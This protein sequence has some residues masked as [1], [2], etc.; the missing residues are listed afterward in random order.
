MPEHSEPRANRSKWIRLFLFLAVATTYLVWRATRPPE[1]EPFVF[2]EPGLLRSIP[3]PG[4]GRA[5]ELVRSPVPRHLGIY[6][7]GIGFLAQGTPARVGPD[8]R[9]ELESALAQWAPVGAGVEWVGQEDLGKTP[10]GILQVDGFDLAWV[11]SASADEGS[12]EVSFYAGD[13]LNGPPADHASPLARFTMDG[14][15]MG[16]PDG[17][18]RAWMMTVDLSGGMEFLLEAPQGRFSWGFAASEEAT[19]PYLLDRGED[20]D[21]RVVAMDPRT[22]TQ[23][24][25]LGLQVPG[26]GMALALHT[27]TPGTRRIYP[28]EGLPSPTLR[29]VS[30]PVGPSARAWWRILGARPQAHYFLWV[31]DGAGDGQMDGLPVL[32]DTSLLLYDPIAMPEGE[33]ALMVPATLSDS[34]WVQAAEVSLDGSI[35]AV[36]NGLRHALATA[37]TGF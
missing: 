20:H 27:E 2:V 16:G 30:S 3:P 8:T 10:D 15:P 17:E 13:S 37:G 24:E 12:L 36:S 22:S 1:P 19:G 14:L 26:A 35:L 33:L 28:E 29:L 6:R 9:L 23:L 21:P 5:I 31:S 7:P 4:G 18:T 32:V 25:A 34:V 11:S